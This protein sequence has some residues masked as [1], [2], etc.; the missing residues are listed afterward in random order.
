MGR[1][2][3]G[4]MRLAFRAVNVFQRKKTAKPDLPHLTVRAGDLIRKFQEKHE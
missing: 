3:K 4:V 2:E 1:V